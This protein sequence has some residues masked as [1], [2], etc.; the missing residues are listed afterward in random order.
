MVDL[1]LQ[2]A[3]TEPVE[4]DAE[5]LAAVDRG[6]DAVDQSLA[7]NQ[8]RVPLTQAVVKQTLVGLA[9]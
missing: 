7:K 6:I 5:T 2:V 1:K 9:G 3:A 4:V 8:Y